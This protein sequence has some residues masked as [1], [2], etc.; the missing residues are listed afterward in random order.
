VPATER[1]QIEQV[2][3]RRA[4]V[5]ACGCV[6]APTELVAD[7]APRSYCSPHS[8]LWGPLAA[9]AIEPPTHP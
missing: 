2:G 9:A 4:H 3:V 1:R 7:P 5:L 8:A 6:R